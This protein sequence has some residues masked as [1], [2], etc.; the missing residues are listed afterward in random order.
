MLRSMYKYGSLVIKRNTVLKKEKCI[1][2]GKTYIQN[3]ILT[4]GT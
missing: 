3:K 4:I 1:Y 2:R